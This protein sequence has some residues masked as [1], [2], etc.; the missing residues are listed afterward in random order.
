MKPK[1]SLIKT[2]L[3]AVMLL[4][5]PAVT[6]AQFNYVVN[7]DDT[8]TITG[9]TGPGGDVTIPATINGLPVTGIGNEAFDISG[10]TSVTIPDSVTN[11]GNFA[12]ETSYASLTNIFVSAAN[13][14]FSSLNGVVFN[15]N[16]T[17]LIVFPNGKGT[18]YTIP[19]SVT[20]IGDYAF[21]RTPL[22]SVTIPDSITSIGKG[23]FEECYKLNGV[24][25]PNSVTNIGDYAFYGSALTS[26]TI[27]DSV[28]NIG[29]EAY[30]FCQS[31]MSVSIGNSVTTIGE[32]AFAYTH[33]VNVTIPSSVTNIG[34]EAF[35]Y[36]NVTSIFF[37]GNAP[38]AD[39]SIFTGDLATVYYLSGT[40][41]WRT[42]YGGL[43]TVMLNAPPQLG[44]TTTGWEYVSDDVKVI[45]ARYVGSDSAVTIPDTINALPVT[46]IGN[47]TFLNIYGY[48]PTS[49]VIPDGVTNIGDLA[50]YN[51]Y[52]NLTNITVNADNPVYS[53][54]NGVMFNKN[55]TTLIVYPNGKSESYTIPGSVTTIGDYAFY[56]TIVTSVTLPNSITYIACNAF[57]SC[58]LAS[59]II[60]DSVT[61]IGSGAFEDC[62]Y[63]TNATIG[64]GVISIGDH[65]F[66]WDNYINTY[67]SLTSVTIG[68][69][70]ANIGD[71]AFAA[72]FLNNVIIPDSV[73]NIGDSAFQYCDNLT[74]LTIGN[75]VIRIGNMA[76]AGA[77][78]WVIENYYDLESKLASVTIGSNVTSIGDGAFQYC[79]NLTSVTIPD[80]VTNIGDSAFWNCQFLTSVTIGAGVISIGD[81]AFA[82]TE[83]L[84]PGTLPHPL[85]NY[86]YREPTILFIGNAPNVGQDVFEDERSDYIFGMFF[87]QIYY[88]PNSTGWSNTF[89]GLPTALLDQQTQC[90][91]T[92][93]NGAVKITGYLGGTG[94]VNIPNNINGMPVTDIG[95]YAFAT[96]PLTGVTIPDSV[97]GIGNS[98]FAGPGFEIYEGLGWVS[99]LT[100]VTIGN[101]VTSIG[102]GAFQYCNNLTSVTIPDSVTNI[103]SW[104]FY[105]CANLTNAAIG[106]G[107][108]SIG[109]EAF[110]ECINLTGVTIPDSVT[111]IGNEAFSFCSGL[112]NVYF[113][114]NAPTVDPGAFIIY[115]WNGGGGYYFGYDLATAYYLPSTTGWSNTF[116]G[117]PTAL[118]LPQAQIGDGSFGVRTNQF[119]FN[120]AW[121]SGQTVVVEAATNLANPVWTPVAT[122]I[123]TSD[124]TYFSDPQWTNYPSRFYRLKYE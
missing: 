112:T 10:L 107:V 36:C 116:A 48:G 56:D 41:G 37:T 109:E 88:L 49:V 23:A 69:S 39:S 30:Q 89:A 20:S 44:T 32:G 43:P 123:L 22:K 33:L 113:M 58:S 60:P 91:Y 9:Y 96:T 57:Q 8:I 95:D 103:G 27:P 16:Q 35:A 15:K 100:S 93:S 82:I 53:S 55:Q 106:R 71:Y 63:L 121:A 110:S 72:T 5:L 59:V 122:N 76:F 3:L 7:D 80:S 1:Q 47:G 31:L 61:N 12:F 17:T 98:A 66:S 13:P 105:D 101:N 70:V 111:N 79:Y 21:N 26:V 74:N 64:N 83:P 90:G 102:D 73:T 117:L 2:C 19:T 81:F 87:R 62:E 14:V 40:T 94:T 67:S 65:A 68:N 52:A 24:T 85:I 4:A 104:V 77:N 124:S 45:I 108:T 46:I 42:T 54:L 120:I 115:Y 78:S 34:D 50:F 28:F 38:I 118:W 92:A 119:G 114:G 97:V 84:N 99:M 25:I 86:R 6:Q 75:G 51:Y 11:I 29:N 18:S